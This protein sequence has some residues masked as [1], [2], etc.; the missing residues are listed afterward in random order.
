MEVSKRLWNKDFSLMV[1]GQIISLFGNTILRFALSMVVLEVSGSAAVFGSITAL[2]MLPTV[3]LTPVGGMIADRLN[4]RNIMVVL[5]FVTAGVIAL[6]GLLFTAS[7][8]VPLIGTTLIVLS[9]I[10]SFYTPSVQASIP[11]LQQA[12]NLVRGNAI[13]NQVTMLAGLV[14]PVLGGVLFGLVGIDPIIVLSGVCFFISA[15]LELFI[16]IPFAKQDSTDGI[17]RTVKRDFGESLRFISKT[18]PELLGAMLL[19]TATNLF[20]TSMLL[21]G[22]PY[23]V[24][25]TLGLSSEYYG[26]ASGCMAGAGLLGGFLSTALAGRLPTRKLYLLLIGTGVFLVPMGIGYLTDS[27]VIALYLITIASAML[28]SLCGSIFSI[29]GLSAIQ[30]KTPSHLLGKVMAYVLTLAMLAQ[31]VGQAM[32][33]FFFEFLPGS[34]VSLVIFATAGAG[35]LVG[36]SGKSICHKLETVEDVPASKKSSEAV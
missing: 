19:C 18:K 35:V 31:P 15:V 22:L 11:T 24:R 26:V 3:L 6:F 28:V 10:Q 34:N 17:F 32:Y 8:K 16:H 4:R 23:L 14:G 20:A 13:V 36:I 25:I 9:I 27:P 21:V 2:S 1:I 30:S 29:F 5:D 7:S 12:D 33:G